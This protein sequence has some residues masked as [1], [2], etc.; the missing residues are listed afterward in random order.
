M[1][2]VGES[3]RGPIKGINATPYEQTWT[4]G[5]QHEVPGGIVLD[6]N[7]VG[8]K[9]TKLFFSG[10]DGSSSEQLNIL[11]P[12]IEKYNRD[13]IADLE[14]YVDNPFFGV[15]PESASLG[16]STVQKYQLLLPYPQFTSFRGVAFPIAN[17]IYHAFQLRAERRF[18]QGLQ[19]LATYTFSKSI[20]DASVTHDGVTWL[21]GTPS[22]Q[23]P[24]NRRLE[25]G[26]SGFDVPHVVGVSYIWELPIGRNK[27]IGGNW[28]PV[29][30]AP[31]GGW[32]T[33][34][35]WAFSNGFPIELSLLGGLSLPTYGV[36]RP[37]LAGTLTRNAG[38]NFRDQYF[39]NPEVVV[40]PEAY[41]IGNAPRTIGSVRTPGINNANLSLLKEFYLNKFREGMRLEYRAEF[42]NAFNH[43]QFCG[44]NTTLDGGTFGQVT[45]TA[46]SAREI[47]MALKFYW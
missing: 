14:T 16:S 25:R 10:G 41:A 33:N 13:Q 46:N 34:G 2:Y 6:A 21:G 38:S 35:I 23:N 8:K 43:P 30:E 11:G 1:S 29:L 45:C 3:L 32:K 4:I 7:Y 19:F 47:Q 17:S 31:L 28:H 20:D 27:A 12:Q 39:A 44:P 37:N 24:N 5:F 40:A 22:L 18:S 42:F 26:L 15:I 9:G 36:Q